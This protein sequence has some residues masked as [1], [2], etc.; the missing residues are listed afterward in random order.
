VRLARWLSIL[1]LGLLAVATPAWADDATRVAS[2][3]TRFRSFG[4]AEGL[5]NLVIVSI[6]QD[7]RGLLWIGSDDGVSSYD[8]ERF[9]HFGLDRG[10]ASTAILVLGVAPDGNVCAG[11]D[12]GLVCWDGKQFSRAGTEGVPRAA[13]YSIV[14]AHGR[15]WVGTVD[16][17]YVR[18]AGAR[19][20]RAT[21][22]PGTGPVKALWVD[23]QGVVAGD[24]SKVLHS[25]G[26]GVW[27]ELSSIGLAGDHIDAVLRDRAGAL[28]IRSALHLWRLSPGA[29][30]A[31]DLSAGLPSGYDNVETPGGMANGPHGEVLLGSD[32]G[33]VVRDGDRW[34]VIGRSAGLPSPGARTLFVDREGV[35]WVGSVGLFQERGGG[36]LERYDVSNGLPGDVAWSI[37]RDREG[38]LWVGTNRCLARMR[39][40]RWEC[41]PG[42]EQRVVRSFVFPPQGGVFLGGAPSDLLYIDP[43]GR[44]VSIGAELEHPAE[45]AILAI[46]I[47]PEGDLWVATK[48]G[49]FRLPGAVP[50]PLERVTIAGIPTGAKYNSLIVAGGRLWAAS[51]Y[52]IA[53]RDRGTWHVYGTAD[54]FRSAAMRYL[55]HT[56]DDEYCVAYNEAIGVT[57]FAVNGLAVSK[58]R[59]LDVADGLIT[60]SVYFLGADRRRRLWIGTGD[61]VDVVTPRG[62][63]HVSESDGLAG[64][65]SAA[66]AFFE[67]TDGSLWFGSTGGVSHLHAEHYDGPPSPPRALVRAGRLGPQIVHER[68]SAELQTSH[69]RNALSVELGSDRLADADRVEY[70]VRLSPLEPEW[71]AALVRQARYPALLPGVYRFEARA[72]VG[73]GAWGP[74]ATLAFVVHPAWWQSRWFVGLAC[75]AIAIVIAVAFTW[76]QRAVLRRRTR[77]LNEEATADLRAL[78]ELVPDL[79]SVHRDGKVIY[80]NLA[81]RRIY[82]LG[83][84]SETAGLGDRIHPDDRARVAEVLQPPGGASWSSPLVELRVRD[85]DGGW[86]TCELSGVRL[87]LAGQAVLVASGRDVTERHRLRAQLLVSDRMASLGTLAAGIAHEINNPLAYVLGNLAMMK[88]ALASP[89]DQGPELAAAIHDATD[90]AQ[91]VRK[92]VQGLRSFSHAGEE[93]RV[94]LEIPELLRAAIRLTANEVRHR[95][96]LVCE[97]GTTPKIVADD[98]RLTQVFINLIVNA[99]HAIPEGRSDANR[100]TVRTRSDDRGHAVVEIEDTGR[101]MSPEVQARAFDPFFT[102]KEVGSGTGL[103]LA[104]C[105]GIIGALGGQIAIE[106]VEARGTVVRVVL[107][108]AVVP[109]I[110]VA[111]TATVTQMTR[112]RRLRILIVDD[113]PLVGDMLARVLRRDH[114]VVVASCGAAALVQITAGP[115]FDAIVSDVMMPNMTGIELLDALVRVDPDQ[116]RRLIFLSG[117]VFTP[118]TRARLDALGTLQLEKPIGTKELRRAVL[119]I[120][121]GSDADASPV[122]APATSMVG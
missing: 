2:G 9:S 116:A 53:V 108:P 121:E 74:S 120:A 88:E 55:V 115:R 24:R 117:G 105:H 64:N 65:D 40:A 119:S 16:G 39:G 95:A 30:R 25:A 45:H 27:H 36:L 103:G 23:A 67:D 12:T 10:L 13:V 51:T 93:T 29:L 118:Q 90:G 42:S 99:A 33:V 35:T 11:S 6:T 110:V 94:H 85:D 109:E 62:I 98:G 76:R 81:A 101:G 1:A 28:W 86:R 32:V 87:E 3:L 80:S 79:I 75:L 91:R 73:T 100:I 72:R 50:G 26:D 54:G 60:G 71:S 56:H 48:I 68:E 104:I 17:L 43:A 5:H 83:G 44:A 15:L 77:Q 31:E 66:N 69:D 41:W 19:F 112:P 111:P 106:S 4:S 102:T 37:A 18:D 122:A 82:G 22:W 114:E 20:A 92:I 63:D 21:G 58:L 59:N 46:K 97:L 57:C 78:L 47:G 14:A 52:G 113:E 8:G 49:L 34:H 96:Q 38:T 84:D 89:D 7:A 107:P 70:Q 61:G